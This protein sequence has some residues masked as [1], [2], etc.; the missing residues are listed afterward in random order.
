MDLFDFDFTSNESGDKPKVVFFDT[1]TTGAKE[2]DQIIEIG[3]IVE[4]QDGTYE[5]FDEMCATSNKRLID[6][7]AMVVHGIRNE[8][9]EGKEPFEKSSFYKRIKELN[10]TANYLV[11]HNLPFDLARLEYYG[12]H[13]KMQCIDT[14]QCAKHLF[15]LNE[16]LGELE[17]PLTN[18]K[19]QSFR[20]ALFNKAEELEESNRYG[21]DIRAHN[22]ISDVVILR[23]FFKEL[24]N[25]I[26]ANNPEYQYTDIL[27]E[28]VVLSTKPVLVKQFN[29]GKYKGRL[30][31]DILEEDR[32]YL[33]W[34]YRD[35]QKRKK[36]NEGIDENLYQTLK[37]L[38]EQQ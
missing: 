15:E 5:L 20:Y 35:I 26:K 25:R 28:L 33:E 7:E 37:S 23:L 32:G 13:V 22:A 3:A 19:L 27:N 30:L 38:L 1:E 14:L 16:P 8:D 10:S 24:V 12:F 17:Y 4:E 6:L 18:Y 31:K 11:A 9:L 21:I 34:L 36:S 2:D 29:F